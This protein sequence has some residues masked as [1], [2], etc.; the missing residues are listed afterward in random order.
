MT[1]TDAA[2]EG[3]IG[4]DLQVVHAVARRLPA[5]P[6]TSR[7]DI[8]ALPVA[9]HEVAVGAGAHSNVVT[10]AEIVAHAETLVMLF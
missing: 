4:G 8:G 7:V 5:T 3:A 6:T 10:D 9:T 1:P 2:R